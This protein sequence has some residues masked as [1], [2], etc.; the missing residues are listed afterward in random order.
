MKEGTAF[1][2]PQK[3]EEKSLPEK[4]SGFLK[5]GEAGSEEEVGKDIFSSLLLRWFSLHGRD[6]PWR[7]EPSPY[8][9]W[10]SEVMLQQTRV[11]A[12]KGYYRRFLSS[13]PDI[14]AL[15]AAEE[16][17][18]LKLWEGL[19]YYSR[20]RNLQKGARLLV[21]QYGGKLP[22]S[23][24]ELRRIPG[25]GDYTAAAIASIAFKERIPAVDGNLLR[26]RLA[27]RMQK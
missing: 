12:V 7:E 20:A 5:E 4:S 15:A 13:L 6:L 23:A 27:Y 22:E 11:E 21:S 10:L 9:V 8:H 25:I 17:L 19:G 14:P 1:T 24:E 18:V 3:E 26:C 2:V 16:E